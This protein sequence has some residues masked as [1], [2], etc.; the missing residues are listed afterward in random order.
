MAPSF[1]HPLRDAYLSPELRFRGERCR[2]IVSTASRR[3]RLFMAKGKTHVPSRGRLMWPL[4]RTPDGTLIRAVQRYRTSD[5]LDFAFAAD[6][7]NLRWLLRA[8][9]WYEDMDVLTAVAHDARI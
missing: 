7:R 9:A 8:P 3:V 1:V 2:V 4:L 5:L 6:G